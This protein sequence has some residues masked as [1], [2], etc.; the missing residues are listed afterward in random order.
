MDGLQGEGD[1]GASV[2]APLAVV[3]QAPADGLTDQQRAFCQAFIDER[4]QIEAA[5]IAAGYGGGAKNMGTRNLAK[6]K[7]QAEIARRLKLQA[8][9]ALAIALGALFRIIE[10]SDDPRAVVQA[11]LGIMDRFGMAPPK[12]P[13]VA[14]QVNN[15][16]GD[17]AQQLLRSVWDSRAARLE[18]EGGA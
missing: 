5:A 3:V 14:V 15:V 9:S 4:G 10:S 6:P 7:I 1:G 11:A 18:A 12:G 2:Q 8:G 13:A 17:A 16:S